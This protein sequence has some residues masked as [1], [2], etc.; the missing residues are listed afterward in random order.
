MKD[1]YEMKCWPIVQCEPFLTVV[2]IFCMFLCVCVC[3]VRDMKTSGASVEV[4]SDEAKNFK[5]L[6]LQDQQM[7]DAFNAYPELLC[8]DATYKLVQLG[9]SLYL[10]LC[11]SVLD[12]GTGTR[13]SHIINQ[14]C[15]PF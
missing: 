7:K 2:I 10:M 14:L 1:S 8:I 15:S 6:F 13:S 9:L 4:Y 12:A 5:G 11:V 3:V